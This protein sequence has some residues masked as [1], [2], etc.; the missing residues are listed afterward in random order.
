MSRELRRAQSSPVN[1]D[2]RRLGNSTSDH[3][4][5]TLFEQTGKVGQRT[6]GKVRFDVQEKASKVA[7]L[8]LDL[9]NFEE[10]KAQHSRYVLTSPRSLEACG[11][12]GIK[13]VELLHKS[14]EEFVEEFTSLYDTDYSH[15]AVREVFQEHE[16]QRLRKL[17]LCREERERIIREKKTESTVSSEERKHFSSSPQHQDNT[18][19]KDALSSSTKQKNP[20]DKDQEEEQNG[21]TASKH[22]ETHRYHRAASPLD[23][24][25]KENV[26]LMDEKAKKPPTGKTKYSYPSSTKSRSPVSPRGESSDSETGV[27]ARRSWS[28]S[29]EHSQR[30]SK[31]PSSAGSFRRRGPQHIKRTASMDSID[32]LHSIPSSSDGKGLS[33]KDQR[34]VN[35]MMSRHEEQER[36]RK[37]RL[38]LEMEWSEQRKLEEQLRQARHRQRQQEIWDTYKAKDAKQYEVRARRLRNEQRLKK[39]KLEVLLSKDYTWQMEKRKQEQIKGNK[40]LAKKIKDAEKKQKQEENL[41]QKEREEELQRTMTQLNLLDKHKNAFTKKTMLFSQEH[42]KVQSRNR[43]VQNRHINTR[44]QLRQ[45]LSQEEE[46]L[47]HEVAIKHQN[48]LMNYQRQLTRKDNQIVFNKLK[49]EERVER[50]QDQLKKITN[51]MDEWR[52]ELSVF[53]KEKDKRAQGTVNMTVASKQQKVK[54][55]LIAEKEEHQH[56]MGRVKQALEERKREIQE[57]IEVKDERSRMVNTEKE[58]IRRLNRDAARTSQAVRDLVREQTLRSSFDRMAETAQHQALVGRGPQTGH[59]NKSSVRLG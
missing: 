24:R 3:E 32:F 42:M 46:N 23:L 52:R 34:I 49:R 38:M 5:E 17:K 1:V 36:A 6:S 15:H 41:W 50:Q 21:W 39:D 51:D 55:Q 18:D 30:K 33:E 57:D 28:S 26:Y 27:E 35:L 59:K 31:K 48:A 37:E 44:R 53:R 10:P 16:R 58:E 29:S 20:Y 40:I 19:T 45:R 56:N 54:S 11:R 12:F 47:K 43:S 4:W 2:K 13:P 8:H 14:L 25:G 7:D 9:F 22:V